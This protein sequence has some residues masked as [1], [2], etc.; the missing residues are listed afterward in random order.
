VCGKAAP[1][2]ITV[3]TFIVGNIQD[4]QIV[5]RNGNVGEILRTLQHRRAGKSCF[6]DYP[7]MLNAKDYPSHRKIFTK[8]L[9]NDIHVLQTV[10]RLFYFNNE[11]RLEH[12]TVE[13]RDKPEHL[14]HF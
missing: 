4:R 5:I 7:G 6:P 11:L 13:R 2:Q 10:S 3:L 9:V 12:N 8:K 1:I 14:H